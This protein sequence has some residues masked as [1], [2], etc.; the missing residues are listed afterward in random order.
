[1]PK[2]REGTAW[3]WVFTSD[4]V[5]STGDRSLG[6]R[7][8]A[9]RLKRL[10]KRVLLRLDAPA[11]RG[12]LPS[13]ASRYVAL[14]PDPTKRP[15][16]Q[17]PAR[18]QHGNLDFQA[19]T[20][21]FSAVNAF[22]HCDSMFRM[23][24][25][26]FRFKPLEKYLPGAQ[27]PVKIV[28]RAIIG[29][30]RATDKVANAEVTLNDD[31][32]GIGE[33]RFALADLVDVREP[34]GIATD[35]RYVW[36]EFGHALLA[37][38]TGGPGR[39]ASLELPFAHSVGDALAAINGDPESKLANDPELR[40]ETLPWMT[41]DNRRHDRKADAFWR[42]SGGFYDSDRYPDARDPH[43]YLAE[44]LL[45]SSLFRLY[46]AIGGD[47]VSHDEKTGK[48]TP[49]V[50]KGK[51]A[52]AYT[53]DVKERKRAAEYVTFLI[54]SAVLQKG[55][56][57]AKSPAAFARALIEA[58]QEPEPKAYRAGAQRPL[59][60]LRKVIH[61]AFER[62]GLVDNSGAPK[63]EWPLAVDVYIGDGRYL[64]CDPAAKYKRSETW[65]A[66]TPEFWISVPASPGAGRARETY[67]LGVRVGNCGS[68]AAN[69]VAVVFYA[70]EG[71]LDSSG[72]KFTP[73]GET[74]T[75]EVPPDAVSTQRTVFQ[76]PWKP[77][78]PGKYTLLAV[79][80]CPEDLSTAAALLL[81]RS[82]GLR[83]LVPYDNNIA[84]R[85]VEVLN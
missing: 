35:V 71:A 80:Q 1:M 5:S 26:L 14:V 42:W 40:G 31:K 75:Q 74:A 16:P 49:G 7:S 53:P 47:A 33:M 48:A 78:K 15:L 19:R 43:G 72:A 21:D 23:L 44:Q 52:A 18:S 3:A 41:S 76:L 37:G 30:S 55:A 81:D 36:H 51:R 61:W 62:Q 50:K 39:K 34:L 84:C 77:A 73:I 60:A 6:P 54:V 25:E 65:T 9:A 24:E 22:Y 82:Y 79:A 63:Y 56:A 2:E 83:D 64:P 4:P 67:V 58:D 11:T 32:S 66:P 27:L 85:E 10:R 29:N 38:A 59:G 46:Q 20:D 8:S 57:K 70:A 28:N 12:E 69:E 13:L 45:S 68:N 17:M